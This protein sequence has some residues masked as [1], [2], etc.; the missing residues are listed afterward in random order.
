M[1][2][3]SCCWWQLRN[4][5]M[6]PNANL[7]PSRWQNVAHR[8]RGGESSGTTK[9]HFSRLDFGQEHRQ[10]VPTWRH[11]DVPECQHEWSSLPGFTDSQCISPDKVET[12]KTRALPEMMHD[13]Q[14]QA[15]TLGTGGGAVD[16]TPLFSAPWGCTSGLISQVSDWYPLI[17][18]NSYWSRAPPCYCHKVKSL[19]VLSHC[20]CKQYEQTTYKN[21]A[22]QRFIS[23]LRLASD[24]GKSKLPSNVVKAKVTKT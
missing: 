11:N 15:R 4:N 12:I 18:P 16:E 7:L 8:G 14:G 2:A 24:D 20:S 5:H 10:L 6:S 17:W 1:A 19:P 13:F 9:D 22:Q 23:S 21:E 3:F